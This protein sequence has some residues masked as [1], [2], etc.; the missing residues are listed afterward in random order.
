MAFGLRYG[1]NYF[2]PD[3]YPNDIFFSR[4]WAAH[5]DPLAAP[6]AP[7][8]RWQIML[9]NPYPHSV[10]TFR[11][12]KFPRACV[13]TIDVFKRCEMINGT[14]KCSEEAND[15]IEVCP[16]WCLDHMKEGVR[17]M[18]KVDAI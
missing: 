7:Q 1:G 6:E 18:A 13:R 9:E 17:F 5:W 11:P 3:E 16:N 14:K 2:I 8:H 12:E 10:L 15:I 4:M